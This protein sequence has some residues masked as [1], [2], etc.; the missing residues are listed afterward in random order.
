MIYQMYAIKDAVVGQIAEPRLFVNEAQAV[1]WF[2]TF[3]AKSDIAADLQLF[4]LG[5]FNA[6]TGEIRSEVQ[7]VCGGGE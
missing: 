4:A 5:E 3:A 2:K 6:S 7:F 1:R